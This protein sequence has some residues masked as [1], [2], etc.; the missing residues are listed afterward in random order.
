[1]Q[2]TPRKLISLHTNM[3]FEGHTSLWN[4]Q[5]VKPQNNMA[6]W[7]INNSAAQIWHASIHSI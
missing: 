1:M 4:R 2:T 3:K 5:H 6:E 7:R